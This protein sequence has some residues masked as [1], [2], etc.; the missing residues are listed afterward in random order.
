MSWSAKHEA[1]N[2]PKL[3][4]LTYAV[5]RLPIGGFY[6]AALLCSID[7]YGEKF[8]E[9]PD[10]K[11]EDGWSNFEALQQVTLKDMMEASLRANFER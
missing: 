10:Y 9:R 6:R 1:Y 8:I 7:R 4:E 2:H 11:P 5:Q 3:H